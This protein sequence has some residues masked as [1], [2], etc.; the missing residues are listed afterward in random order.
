[1]AVTALG[2]SAKDQEAMMS[3]YEVYPTNNPDE[4][5]Q[6]VCDAVKNVP[7]SGTILFKATDRSGK[8][9]SFN[10]GDQADED[11]R[12]AAKLPPRLIYLTKDL[13]I[14]GE[15]GPPASTGS[16][17]TTIVGGR[18]AFLWGL[19]PTGLTDPNDPGKGFDPSSLVPVSVTITDITFQRFRCGVVRIFAAHDRNEISGCSFLNYL[20]GQVHIGGISGGFPIVADGSTPKLTNPEL[21]TGDLLIKNNHFGATNDPLALASSMNNLIHL[22]NCNLK[23]LRFSDNII[24]DMCLCGVAVWGNQGNTEIIGNTINKTLMFQKGKFREGAGISIGITPQFLGVY[25]GNISIK[26]N[27]LTINSP[28]S[29]GIML[30]LFDGHYTLFPNTNNPHRNVTIAEN[31]VA[32]GGVDSF[33]GRAALSCIGGTSNSIWEKNTVNGKAGYGIWVSNRVPDFMATIKVPQPTSEN[34][35]RDNLLDNFMATKSQILCTN[36]VDLRLSKN[37]FGGIDWQPA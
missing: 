6:N 28:N 32:M 21:I 29:H 13:K 35:F 20:S 10:F 5:W 2:S 22:A 4:D 18:Q 11:A 15:S 8:A 7:K 31:T 26:H 27:T 36:T 14:R 19:D 23:L 9:T 25:D 16:A 37:R 24:D 17:G 12:K 33:T 30:A 34:E 3:L 1:L